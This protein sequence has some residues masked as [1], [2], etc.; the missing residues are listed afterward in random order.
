MTQMK[1][2][3]E[4]PGRFNS[5]AASSRAFRPFFNDGV[6]KAPALIVG[7]R[8]FRNP[9]LSDLPKIAMRTGL[10]PTTMIH[11]ENSQ[12]FVWPRQPAD[13][14]AS[15]VWRNNLMVIGHIEV[16]ASLRGRGLGARNAAEMFGGC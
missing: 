7:Q 2:S 12:R 13:G 9:P 6:A 4:K 8:L 16:D 10:I 15:Y 3:P 5:D 14:F 1:L 11:D